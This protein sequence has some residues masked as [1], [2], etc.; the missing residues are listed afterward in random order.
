MVSARPGWYPDPT[1]QPCARW[2]DGYM[3]TDATCVIAPPPAPPYA[4]E[5][6]RPQSWYVSRGTLI[7]GGIIV[8]LIIAFVLP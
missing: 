2:F 6:G 4:S 7:A 8:L 5:A 3:W 1:G